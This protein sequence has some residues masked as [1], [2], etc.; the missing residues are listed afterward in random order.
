MS[1][2]GTFRIAVRGLVMHDGKFLLVKRSKIARGEYGFW[3]LPGGGLD[4]GES[5]E[6]ALKRELQEEVQMDIELV[7][8]LGVWHY[9]RNENVQIIGFTFL[10]NTNQSEAILSHEHLE[11]VWINKDEISN[12]K[13]FPELL[14][15]FEEWVEKGLIS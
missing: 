6:G 11:Y 12:Y 9:L 2:E 4:F 13:V 8:P 3:E 5:P 7:K 15:E 10:C 14:L 1:N